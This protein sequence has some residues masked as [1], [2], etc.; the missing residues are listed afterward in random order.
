MGSNKKT[1][2]IILGLSALI[3]L[4]LIFGVINYIKS[5]NNND[6][7]Y[8]FKQFK[9]TIPKNFEFNG[10]EGIFIVHPTNNE[11]NV[12]IQMGND[13]N[14]KNISDIYNSIV[15][16]SGVSDINHNN[17]T[18]NNT[19][20]L[21]LPFDQRKTKTI[22]WVTSWG[23]QYYLHVTY[24]TDKFDINKLTPVIESLNNPLNLDE[25]LKSTTT[26][27]VESN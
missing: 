25:V 14:L 15:K 2:F 21:I 18:I 11:W 8:N 5:K 26:Q 12:N 7:I 23:Y 27:V 3:I 19:N 1:T 22:I 9:Y 13:E 10:L 20:I 16:T 24:N 4:V 6:N 17:L